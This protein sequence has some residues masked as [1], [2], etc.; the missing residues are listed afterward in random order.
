LVTYSNI[1]VP[2]P[3]TD[4]CAS[5][6]AEGSAPR[7]TQLAC[8]ISRPS[9]DGFNKSGYVWR[10]GGKHCVMTWMQKVFIG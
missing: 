1:H 7:A 10:T 5:G 9:R 8:T 6:L 2:Q 3:Q 4:G